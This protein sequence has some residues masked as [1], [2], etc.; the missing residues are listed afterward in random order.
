M[1]DFCCYLCYLC[2]LA[3][4]S[5]GNPLDRSRLRHRLLNGPPATSA[6]PGRYLSGRQAG[7][8]LSTSAASSPK[9]FRDHG[10]EL[11]PNATLDVLSGS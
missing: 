3:S 11:S 7:M 8:T 6:G 1:G 2:Y 4:L 5:C 9:G 10:E